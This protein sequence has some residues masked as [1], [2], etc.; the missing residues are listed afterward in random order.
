MA[1]SNILKEPRREIVETAVGLV[2]VVAVLLLLF[3][4]EYVNYSWAVSSTGAHPE[5]ELPVWF[6]VFIM[7]V[8]E[9]TALS[10]GW[11]MITF[12]HLVGEEICDV[13]QRR[14]IHLRPRRRCGL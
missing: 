4:V 11:L 6:T 8:F 14:G 12:I 9:I 5:Y 10:V 2:P 3:G 1:L 7:S 13:L